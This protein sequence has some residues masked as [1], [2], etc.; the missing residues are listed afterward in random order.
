MKVLGRVVFYRTDGVP[1]IRLYY[2]EKDIIE[3]YVKWPDGLTGK[4][5]GFTRNGYLKY[6][7]TK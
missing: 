5:E 1:M 3:Q 2:K 6:R 7:E 4:F